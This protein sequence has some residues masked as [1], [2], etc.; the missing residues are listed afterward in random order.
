MKTKLLFLLTLLFVLS[1][2]TKKSELEKSWILVEQRKKSD[3]KWTQMLRGLLINFNEEELNISFITSEKENIKPYSIENDLI[4]FDSDTLGKILHLSKDSLII[5]EDSTSF[6]MIFLPLVETNFSKKDQKEI[7]QNLVDNPWNLKFSKYSQTIYCDTLSWGAEDSTNRNF[8]VYKFTFEDGE[9]ISTSEWWTLK[10]FENSLIFNY[11]YGQAEYSFF[12]ITENKNDTLSGQF[13]RPFDTKWSN[14]QFVKSQII[15]SKAKEDLKNMILGDWR[16]AKI[17][18]PKAKIL[19]SITKIQYTGL[20]K[21]QYSER[22]T[23]SDL[24]KKSVFFKFRTNGEFEILAGDK[25]IRKGKNWSLSDDG[26][27][28]RLDYG[29]VGSDFVEIIEINNDQIHLKKLEELGVYKD[30]PRR[31]IDITLNLKLEKFDN[32]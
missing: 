6:D 7:Y 15:S 28:I 19:E 10:H 23:T 3:A 1:C 20:G 16:S 13:M 22:M 14:N 17:I 2:S 27:Y 29:I 11:S 25:T 4:I 8:I 5:E 18:E 32:K 9:E 26:K 21:Y 31:F 24:R 12:Q 30:H